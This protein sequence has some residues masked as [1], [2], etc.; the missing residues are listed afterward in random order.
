MSYCSALWSSPVRSPL[1]PLGKNHVTILL[2]TFNGAAHVSEQL[3]SYT[4]QTHRDWSLLV[5]DDGS[6]DDTCAIIREFARQ[7]PARVDSTECIDGV[8]MPRSLSANLLVTTRA[9]AAAISNGG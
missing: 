6:T 1:E 7:Q 5:S 9:P 2:A 4:A 3:E 8:S